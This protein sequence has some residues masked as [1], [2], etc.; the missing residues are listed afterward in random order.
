LE[1]FAIERPETPSPPSSASL[2]S[3]RERAVLHGIAEG[4]SI[5]EIATLLVI[6]AHTVRTHMKNIYSKLDAHNRVQALEHARALQ[7]L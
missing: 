6:S 7:L 5:Q 4:R 2:L 1:A 3:E